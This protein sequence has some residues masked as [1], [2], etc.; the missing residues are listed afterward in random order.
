VETLAE[1]PGADRPARWLIE[2]APSKEARQ[3]AELL[4]LRLA[5]GLPGVVGDWASVPHEVTT[6]RELDP[7][8]WTPFGGAAST[9]DLGTQAARLG[10]GPDGGV[11]PQGT[12][13]VCVLHDP[14]AAWLIGELTGTG[15]SLSGGG[16][17]WLVERPGRGSEEHGRGWALWST[18]EEFDDATKTAVV[19]K[20]KAKYATAGAVGGFLT[21]VLLFLVDAYADR[22]GTACAAEDAFWW[23]AIAMVT[24]GAGLNFL[25]LFEYDRLLMPPRFWASRPS[26]SPSDRLGP[27]AARPGRLIN[28]VPPLLRRHLDPTSSISR[29]PLE[30]LPDGIVRRPPGGSPRQIVQSAQLIWSRFVATSGV[31]LFAG[32]AFFAAAITR[33]AGPVSVL[34]AL[35]P[36]V[37]A[38]LVGLVLFVAWR[39]YRPPIGSA[40]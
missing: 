12:G 34:V 8:R 13:R 31:L 39:R 30:P 38:I 21:G 15:V 7:L 6:I 24:L 19:E 27:R 28:L 23:L 36:L 40:D 22:V 33:P 10:E 9:K 37:G 4:R 3:T 32:L 5:G 25:A 26:P 20:V 14:H 11:L 29:E 1:L 2:S 16:V 35:I 18:I 17:A